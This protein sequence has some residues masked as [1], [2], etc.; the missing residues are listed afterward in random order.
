M[1]EIKPW[2]TLQSDV[3]YENPRWKIRKDICQLPEGTIVQDYFVREEADIAVVF[4]VTK[5]GE[6]VLVKQFRQAANAVTTE[7]PGG[8][9]ERHDM[10]VAEAARRELLEETGYSSDLFEEI[11]VWEVSPSSSTAKMYLYFSGGAEKIAAPK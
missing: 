3:V 4:C 7:L 11:A 8:L 6:V 9:R 2:K 10:S 5:T 1:S